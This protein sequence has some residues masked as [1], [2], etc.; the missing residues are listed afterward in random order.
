MYNVSAILGQE[1]VD[2]EQGLTIVAPHVMNRRYMAQNTIDYTTDNTHGNN[3][4]ITRQWVNEKN[5]HLFSS[6]Y[7]TYSPPAYMYAHGPLKQNMNQLKLTSQIINR[8][9]LPTAMLFLRCLKS[10]A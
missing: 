8:I 7:L 4:S 6:G 10:Q 1:T 3:N 5:R 2:S 9:S